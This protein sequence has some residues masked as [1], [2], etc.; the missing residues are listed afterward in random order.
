MT[1]EVTDGAI[2]QIMNYIKCI[3]YKQTGN[4]RRDIAFQKGK[5]NMRHSVQ[6]LNVFV[7]TSCVCFRFVQKVSSAK[8]RFL[9]ELTT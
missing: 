2:N 1:P 5:P 7:Q 3:K 6:Y 4:E 9:N 8:Y